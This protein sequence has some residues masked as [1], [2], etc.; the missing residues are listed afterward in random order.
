MAT[1]SSVRYAA[2]AV[3]ALL[4]VLLPRP[5]WAEDEYC[6]TRYMPGQQSACFKTLFEAE[7]YIRTEPAPAIGNSLLQRTSERDLSKGFFLFEYSVKRRALETYVDDFY[8]AHFNGTTAS[9]SSSGDPPPVTFPDGDTQKWCADETALGASVLNS[10]YYR[11][12]PYSGSYLGAYSSEQPTTWSRGQNG[13]AAIHRNNTPGDRRFRVP[14]GAAYHDWMVT[15]MDLYR[16]PAL[17]DSVYPNSSGNPVWQWPVVCNNTARAQI[18]KRSVQHDSCCRD[19]NPVV[20]ATGNKEYGEAD[21]SWEGGEFVR[22]Y[23]SLRD[24]RLLSGLGDNWAHSFSSRLVF[25]SGAPQTW[26]RSDGYFEALRLMANGNY[27][28]YNREGVVLLREPDAAAAELGRWRLSAVSGELLWF[29]EA[30]RLSAFDRAGLVFRLEYCT[31]QNVQNGLCLAEGDLLSVVSPTGRRLTLQ[32]SAVAPSAPDDTGTRI[33]R[34]LVDGAV[35]VEYAYDPASRLTHA[36]KGGPATGEGREYLYAESARLCR[37]AAGE[38][39]VGCDP[40]AYPNLLTGVIDENGQRYATYEYNERGRVVVSDHPGGAGRISLSYVESGPTTVTLP[41]GARKTYTFSS[42]FRQPSRIEQATSDGSSIGATTANYS[43]DRREWSQN[44]SGSRTIYAYNDFYQ[45]SRREGL[46]SG[47]ATTPYSRTIQTDWNPAYAKPTERRT[48]DN[49]NV[50]VAKTRWTYNDRGQLL[51][52]TEVDPVTSEERTS[53]AAYCEA[54]DVA[55]GACPVL[56]LL[57]S[58]DGPR[59]D[60]ADVTTYTY[61]SADEAS[62][63]GVPTTCAYRKGDLWKVANALGQTVEYLRYDHAGRALSS[64][65]ANGVV[66]DLEYTP[67]GWLSARKVRGPDSNAETDDAITRY[68]YD[69]VGQVRKVTQPDGSYVRYEYDAAQRL[70]DIVDMAGNRIHYT[71]DAAGNRIK[72]DTRDA[73]GTLKRTLSRIYNQLGQL[74]TAK[75]AE[76]H[77]TGYTYDADGN[78]D[79]VT[80]ALGR[81]TDS[82]YDP[83]G[84]LAKTLQDVGGINAKT[85]FK[86]DAQDRLVRVTDP[87][88]LNTDHGYN[89]FGD[90]TRLNS[91]DTGVS[92]FTY[93]SAGN[94]KTATDARGITQTYSYDALNR[95]TGVG[96][97]TSSLDVAYTYDSVPAVC[98]AGETF[99]LGR[100]TLMTDG[101]G[102]TQYCYSRFG[103]L[104]RVVQKIGGKAFTIRYAYDLAGN[105]N[106]IVYPDQTAISYGRDERGYIVST[107][108]EPDDGA[109]NGKRLLS[110]VSYHPFGPTAGWVYG[111]GRSMVRSVDMDY[112]IAS[113]FDSTAEG[114]SVGFNFDAAGNVGGLFSLTTNASLLTFNYDALDRLVQVRD[115]PSAA[116]IDSYTY[117]ATGNRLSFANAGGAQTY[118]YPVDSHRLSQVGSVDYRNYDAAGNAILIAGK[119]FVYDD[120]GRISEVKLG[121]NSLRVFAY[122]GKGEQVLKR[123]ATGERYNIYDGFG[124]WIGEYDESGKAVQQVVWMNELPVG[125][126]TGSGAQLAL[127]YIE[128]DHLSSPRMVVEPSRNVPVWVWDMKGEA[129]GSTMPDQDHDRDGVSLVLD[130]RFPGQRYDSVIGMNYNYFRDYDPATGRYIQSDPIGLKGGMSTYAYVGGSPFGFIDP[131]GLVRI[132]DCPSCDSSIMGDVTRSTT[133]WCSEKKLDRRIKDVAL[134]N[135]IKSRCESTLVVCDNNCPRFKCGKSKDDPNAVITGARGHSLPDDPTKVTLCINQLPTK[136]GWGGTAVHEFAHTCEKSVGGKWRHGDGLGVPN[137]FG[138]D[139]PS[140]S[141]CYPM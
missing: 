113:I 40:A 63:A 51:T 78:G 43:G 81:K 47:G 89:G 120:A 141:Q 68:E 97:P 75:T 67:R 23:N 138:P 88:N 103:H 86:Y 92:T 118:A 18:V 135:C 102:S 1:A 10:W 19:G 31:S 130:M 79:V 32:Y 98:A 139:K 105:L 100:L 36:S 35:Q 99:T 9:C 70:T 27:S 54:S 8:S 58:R 121:S 101:S 106:R 109:A 128:P 45:I 13:Y 115:G 12:S 34:I 77:P 49:A 104:V 55:A 119:T 124:Q 56:G 24:F 108:I 16:C 90:Q 87:K 29:D 94:R 80:D 125:L 38:T 2:L 131:S 71:L 91:P 39:I 122:N 64:K 132:Q 76:G 21:F 14:N 126:L 26:L 33:A 4:A 136:E 74:K 7:A 127:Y 140:Q 116:V 50:L 117:D 72:E 65:D 22:R 134:R 62:C 30:G 15:R 107:D 17:F 61:Y 60:V 6:A 93:D 85:E 52:T 110:G 133:K 59:S 25:Y 96:Y 95:V 123:S 41:T 48:L 69:F 73:G 42:D 129:F 20:A 112:R 57:K 37:N 83:L 66:T 111:N 3:L 53:S 28:S 137:D 82:D 84:R 11:G 5:A 44:A 46:T 114:L